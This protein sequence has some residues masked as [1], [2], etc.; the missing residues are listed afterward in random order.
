MSEPTDEQEFGQKA[1]RQ[2][3]DLY[4]TPEVMRRQE[5]GTLPKPLPFDAFQ[6]VWFP[7]GRPHQVRINRS[8]VK[9]LLRVE[10]KEGV[11]K[12]P[13]ESLLLDEMETFEGVELTDDDDPDCGHATYMRLGDRW[14]GQ[15]DAIYNKGLARRHLEVGAEFQKAA[16]HALAQN[17]LHAFTDNLFS[18]AELYAKA[19]L[20]LLAG[21]GFR[22]KATHEG[23][24]SH[25]NKHGHLGNVDTA[26]AGVLNRLSR[27][28]NP[29]RYLKGTLVLPREEADAM[30]ASVAEM[31][32]QAR[33]FLPQQ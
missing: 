26:H 29:A 15:F 8:E 18:A 21:S 22:E 28:R 7:D 1:F 16:E 31:E 9:A 6:I 14:Y 27:L 20:L 2:F 25:Y 13:G 11:T 5:A 17:H 19:S 4:V 24:K 23:I 30:L 3:L 33:R 12:P 32:C 10:V